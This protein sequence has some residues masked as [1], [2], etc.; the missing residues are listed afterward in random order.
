MRELTIPARRNRLDEVLAFYDEDILAQDCIRNVKVHLHV[1]IEEIFVN[2]AS[3]AYPDGEGMVTV[4]SEVLPGAEGEDPTLEMKFIDQGIPFDP[5]AKPDPDISLDGEHRQIG[6]LGIY[7]VKKRMDEV[8]YER[9]GDR[10]ILT[11]YKKLKK[12]K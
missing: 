12:E 5:L 11:I 1:A 4:T 10:N 2:I 6:G 9:S 8:R 7:M 3:Y